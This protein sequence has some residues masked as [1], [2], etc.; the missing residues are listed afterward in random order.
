MTVIVGIGG[1]TLT[2]TSA[3]EAGTAAWSVSVPADAAYITGTSVAVAVNA[4][5]TGYS[6]PGPRSSAR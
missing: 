4:S 3:D 1:T 2:A 6:P 5:K